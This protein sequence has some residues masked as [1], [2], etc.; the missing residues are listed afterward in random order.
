MSSL[1]VS[2]MK[3]AIAKFWSDFQNLK[4]S[5]EHTESVNG[6][7]CD[8]MLTALQKLD[9]NLYFEFSSSPG[10]H[11]FII[12]AEGDKSLFPLVDEII[13]E[14]PEIPNWALFALKPKRGFPKIARWEG[15]EVKIGDVLVVPV[16]RETGEMGLELYVPD[17][18]KSNEGDIHNALLR[19]LDAGL[20]ERRF[21]ESVESTWICPAAEAPE[22]AFKLSELEEW[23]DQG[24][25]E[26]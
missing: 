13:C 25:C 16:F 9:S 18:N 24:D 11:E 8:E 4:S 21:A 2:L 10:E 12:T 20:G 3:E 6:S 15:T 7:P 22:H 26:G 19:A 23:I 1:I 14:A 5:L 17:L